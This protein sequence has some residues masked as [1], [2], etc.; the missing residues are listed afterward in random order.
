MALRAAPWGL[1]P[2]RGGPWLGNVGIVYLALW[3]LL[4]SLAFSWLTYRPGL[5]L[6]MVIGL[7]VAGHALALLLKALVDL[8]IHQICPKCLRDMAITATRCPWCHFDEQETR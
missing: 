6:G 7:V 8:A 2:R 1:R 3:G 5:W 4:G